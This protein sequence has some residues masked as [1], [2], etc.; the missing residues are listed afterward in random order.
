MIGIA[1]AA[2]G[3]HDALGKM[4]QRI[5]LRHR[6]TSVHLNC[7]IAHRSTD[8]L[9][10]A[11]AYP[12]PLTGSNPADPFNVDSQQLHSSGSTVTSRTVKKATRHREPFDPPPCARLPRCG[13]R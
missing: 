1:K 10:P 7:A 13:C 6:N 3:Y 9:L 8:E 12:S 11:M 2:A 5:S 4:R